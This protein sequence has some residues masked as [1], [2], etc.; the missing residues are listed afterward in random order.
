MFYLWL[1]MLIMFSVSTGLQLGMGN[2]WLAL[3]NSC[4]IAYAFCF[5]RHFYRNKE[6]SASTTPPPTQISPEPETLSS[7][8]ASGYRPRGVLEE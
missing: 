6:P 2:W 7:R 4:L 3:F 8:F 5:V 1:G